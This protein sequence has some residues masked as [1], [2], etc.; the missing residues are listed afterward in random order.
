MSEY[1]PKPNYLGG[2]SKVELNVSNYATKTY[3]KNATRVD[4]SSFAKKRI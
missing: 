4:T 2:N 1:F 3:L